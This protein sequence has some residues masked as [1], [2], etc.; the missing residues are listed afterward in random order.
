M[1]I[2][3]IAKLDINWPEAF[4]IIVGICVSAWVLVTLI[5]KI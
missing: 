2:E 1:G 5:K 3:E 4:V